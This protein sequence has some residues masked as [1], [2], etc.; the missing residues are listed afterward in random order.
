VLLAGQQPDLVS[1]LL[2]VGL[3]V[4]P[5]HHERGVALL[6]MR[7]AITPAN[8]AVVHRANLAA[9]MIHQASLIDNDTVDLQAA[10]VARDRMRS[11]KLVTTD[12]CAIA[13]RALQC[14]FDCVWGKEDVL[15]C[16]RWSAVHAVCKASPYCARITLVP[17][18]GHWVQYEQA[19]VFNQLLAAWARRNNTAY[20]GTGR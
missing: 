7:T 16:G 1:R 8:R 4:V 12:A 2:L 9:I 17:D 15:Y 19:Q 20:V 13:V 11:R 6:P 14:E 18:A 10:N 3:P 5:L